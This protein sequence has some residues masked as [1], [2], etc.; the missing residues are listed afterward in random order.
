[1]E[2][3]TAFPDWTM[4]PHFGRGITGS[5]VNIGEDRLPDDVHTRGEFSLDKPFASQCPKSNAA[6]QL[7]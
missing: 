2:F 5:K 3:R 1:V 7:N 6:D 4:A